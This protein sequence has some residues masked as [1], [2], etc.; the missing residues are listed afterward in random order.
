MIA[1]NVG[2]LSHQNYADPLPSGALTS[3]DHQAK[4]LV[5]RQMMENI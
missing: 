3:R 2:K 4:D 5:E 1:E